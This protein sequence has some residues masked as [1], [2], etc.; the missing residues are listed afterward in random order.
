MFK[1]VEKGEGRNAVTLRKHPQTFKTIPYFA[2]LPSAHDVSIMTSN[3]VTQ[4]CF[5][6]QKM[7]TLVIIEST[8]SRY[9]YYADSN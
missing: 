2:L 5:T 9:L 7:Q 8:Y 1:A 3:V 4:L 6:Y